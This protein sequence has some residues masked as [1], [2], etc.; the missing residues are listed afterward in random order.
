M[1]K[2]FSDPIWY[3]WMFWTADFLNKRF[4]ISLAELALPLV[5]IYLATDIGSVGGGWLSS[6]LLRR[7]WTANA[8]RK[9]AMFVCAVSVIPVIAAA[10]TS[11]LWIAV[12]VLALATAAHQGWSANL[13]TIVS[14]MFPRRCVGSV[15]GM[16]GLAGA[17]G[18]MMVTK[19]VG[20]VLQFTGSYLPVFF[21]AASAYLFALLL[22]HLLVPR[23]E[24]APVD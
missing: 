3:V 21:L 14:D 10:Y 12:G 20:Y 7:G 8:S 22:I 2:F 24:P 18:G 4:G 9:T 5:I 13:Y 11:N 16:G 1:G 6:F 15:I 17:I 19:A 23:L